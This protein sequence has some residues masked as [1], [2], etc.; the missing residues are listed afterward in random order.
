[1]AV[2]IEGGAIWDEPEWGGMCLGRWTARLPSLH[3]CIHVHVHGR[4]AFLDRVPLDGKLGHAGL[5]GEDAS[6]QPGQGLRGA[7][8]FKYCMV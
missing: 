4:R 5:V 6:H 1:M 7:W 8:G 2:S 3:G